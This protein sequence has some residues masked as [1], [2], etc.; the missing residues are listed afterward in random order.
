MP[1]YDEWRSYTTR[2]GLPSDKAFAVRVDGERV[3]VGTD[4][5]LA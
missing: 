5:G 1:V 4:A 3:W 2:D